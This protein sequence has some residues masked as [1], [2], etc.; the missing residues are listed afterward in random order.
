VL[1][2]LSFCSF[3]C[4]HEASHHFLR[5]CAVLSRGIKTNNH[6]HT[7]TNASYL[8]VL[9]FIFITTNIVTQ[10]AGCLSSL[11]NTMMVFSTPMPVSINCILY[12]F[13]FLPINVFVVEQ[14]QAPELILRCYG[15]I[16]GVFIVLVELELPFILRLLPPFEPRNLSV[17]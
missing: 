5:V 16:F 6:T 2:H 12:I 4:S 15:V 9:N 3:Q 14:K 1:A 13:C 7:H 10:I 11:I 17:Y 8:F